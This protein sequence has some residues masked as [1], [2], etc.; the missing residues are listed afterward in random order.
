MFCSVDGWMTE[1][2]IGKDTEAAVAY[3]KVL[4]QLLSGRTEKNH[5]NPLAEIRNGDLPYSTQA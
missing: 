4:H 1:G 2:R 5:A 3:F